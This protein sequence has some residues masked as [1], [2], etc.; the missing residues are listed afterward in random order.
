MP[1]L[2]VGRHS[3]LNTVAFAVNRGLERRVTQTLSWGTHRMCCGVTLENRQP[4]P[5]LSSR[6]DTALP[7]WNE[8]QGLSLSHWKEKEHT[9]TREG[10]IPKISKASVA[11]EGGEITACLRIEF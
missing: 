9:F 11:A 8:K 10:L 4:F 3:A 6:G 7:Y 2:E 1:I 5:H